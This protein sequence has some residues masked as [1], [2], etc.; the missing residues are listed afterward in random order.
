MKKF[1]VEIAEVEAEA[2]NYITAMWDSDT[3]PD[4][5]EAEDEEE[6]IEIATD[7]LINNGGA[8]TVENTLFRVTEVVEND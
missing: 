8:E 4:H 6:A 3:F 5:I 1:K 7:Y 2:E